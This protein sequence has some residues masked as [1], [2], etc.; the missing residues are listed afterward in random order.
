VEWNSHGS[1]RGKGRD[2]GT[3]VRKIVS[4]TRIKGHTAKATREDPQYL[5]RSEKGGVAAHRPDALDRST[6]RN[7]D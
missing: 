7:G 2:I 1:Q 6:D 5:V 3:V 4:A